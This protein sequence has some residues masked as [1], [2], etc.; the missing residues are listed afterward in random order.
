L[1][2]YLLTKAKKV[3]IQEVPASQRF[4]IYNEGAY[5][6]ESS[7]IKLSYQIRKGKINPNAE[8]FFTE[9]CPDPLGAPQAQSGL[10]ILDSTFYQ[11]FLDSIGHASYS[12]GLMKKLGRLRDSIANPKSI[13]I[14]CFVLAGLYIAY[15]Y[16]H[17]AI[18]I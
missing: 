7:S 5:H 16:L 3:I 4:W 14:I 8:I 6:L 10:K 11:N 2:L 12:E 17:G 13:S 15:L 1:K 9:G 18:K